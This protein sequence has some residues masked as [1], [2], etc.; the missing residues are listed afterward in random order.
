LFPHPTGCGNFHRCLAYELKD[1]VIRG[2]DLADL[3]DLPAPV[4]VKPVT[5]TVPV[6][7]LINGW[8]NAARVRID[9]LLVRVVT[10]ASGRINLPLPQSS[11][12]CV[13]P[14]EPTIKRLQRRDSSTG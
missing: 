13:Q 6:P 10:A 5:V 1:V 8:F 2:K 3:A 4:R 9:G 14:E 12:G 11:G 7:D